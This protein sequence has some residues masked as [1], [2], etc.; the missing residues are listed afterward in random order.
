MGKKH[1]PKTARPFVPVACALIAI[2]PVV[3]TVD[4]LMEMEMAFEPTLGKFL[5]LEF[6]VHGHNEVDTFVADSEGD[7]DISH[8][9]TE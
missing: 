3:P 5:G 2:V 8:E 9:K 4:H 7:D 6:E 1:I